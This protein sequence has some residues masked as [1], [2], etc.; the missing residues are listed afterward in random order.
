MTTKAS[1]F[2]LSDIVPFITPSENIQCT[3]SVRTAI[4]VANA[5]TTVFRF[6]PRVYMESE[7]EYLPYVMSKQFSDMLYSERVKSLIE[8]GRLPK[9]IIGNDKLSILAS[10][11]KAH[12]HDLRMIADK[13]GFLIIPI[14]FMHPQA[15]ASETWETKSAVKQFSDFN[16]TKSFTVYVLC[17][18]SYYYLKAHVQAEKDIQIYVGKPNEQ[19]FMA[20]G[21]T[22]PMFRSIHK[23]I[24]EMKNDARQLSSRQ[25]NLE[26]EMTNLATRIASLEK[27]FEHSQRE[28][29]L[30]SVKSVKIRAAIE[31][32][33]SFMAYEPLAFLMPTERTLTSETEVFLGPC[34]GPDF[35]AIL[36]EM[37]ALEKIKEQREL[38]D[39]YRSIWSR[40]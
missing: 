39:K 36:L 18:P 22:I 16:N 35:P 32:E 25:N 38:L 27:A 26:I 3:S 28:A 2:N 40:V 7:R 11:P 37:I 34:W 33:P 15:T 5:W 10:S 6:I 30:T 23:D 17:P 29:A 1:G 4:E 31:S 8:Y 9:E 20:V 12:L 24:Q 13:L 19:A 21:M 14:Q